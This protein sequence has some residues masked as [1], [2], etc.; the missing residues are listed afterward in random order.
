MIFGQCGRFITI[1]PGQDDRERRPDNDNDDVQHSWA[2]VLG[3]LSLSIY[4]LFVQLL[5]KNLYSITKFLSLGVAAGTSNGF[6]ISDKDYESNSSDT[7]YQSILF[8]HFVQQFTIYLQC[9]N[10]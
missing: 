7:F 4:S 1:W 10:F 2:V 3:L 8:P 9:Y 5:I 6:V